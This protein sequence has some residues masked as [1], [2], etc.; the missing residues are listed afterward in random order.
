[1]CADSL[2]RQCDEFIDMKELIEDIQRKKRE[3]R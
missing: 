3:A 1:M 2:R